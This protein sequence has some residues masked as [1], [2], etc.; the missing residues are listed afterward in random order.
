MLCELES[1]YANKIVVELVHIDFSRI[2]SLLDSLSSGLIEGGL[3]ERVLRY[4][5]GRGVDD[6]EVLYV[7][8]DRDEIYVWLA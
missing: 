2:K 4:E 8:S 6:L 7:N 1:R 5:L 3:A